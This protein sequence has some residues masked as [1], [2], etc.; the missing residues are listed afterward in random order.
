MNKRCVKLTSIL[1]LLI[2]SFG[3]FSA[4]NSSKTTTPAKNELSGAVTASGSTALLPLVKQAATDFMDSNKNVN[5]TV[6]GGGSGTG[7]QQAKDGVVDIGNSDIEAES[8]SGLVDHQI[9]I[10]PFAFVVNNGVKVTSLTKNQL[11]G[12]FS[13]N[14]TN[15]KNV[16]GEDSKI[17]VI[18]RQASSG[19][20]RVI[21]KEV[22]GNSEF[23][24]NAVTGDSNGAV[25]TT[26]INTPNSIG[27]VDFAYVDTKLKAISYNGIS[28]TIENVKNGTYT[29]TSI[30][31]M[32]TK[33]QPNPQA[34]AFIDYIQS[35]DFQNNALPKY[36]FVPVKK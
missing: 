22:M 9:A 24:K 29:L 30:G 26:V 17:M 23:T 14:I 35:P 10:E 20:R 7:L 31:H 1:F 34:K 6:A 28:P 4:C 15:W 36:Q 3:I 5:V 8:G 2:C 21:Q 12:I 11:I 13:G 33:A 27:Y 32:Y 18:T 16:G 25:K 19:T